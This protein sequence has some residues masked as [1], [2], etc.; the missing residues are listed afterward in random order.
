[1]S[2]TRI[3]IWGSCVSRDSFEHFIPDEFELLQYV[4]RQSAIS[5]YTKPVSLLTPPRLESSFQQRMVAGDY[6]S[7]LRDL[8]AAH[9][10]DVDL[11]LVD[12]TDERLGIYVLPDGTVITRSV[13]L[14][15]SGAEETLPP[16]THFVSFGSG[17]HFEYW[18][19]GIQAVGKMIREAMPR[20]AVAL[21]NIPWAEKTDDGRPSSNSFG[22]TA[23]DANLMFPAYVE[24]AR[25]ALGARLV[26]AEGP[27][28][29]AS[30][31]HP[32]GEAPFHYTESV[33]LDVTRQITGKEGRRVWAEQGT[34]ERTGGHRENSPALTNEEVLR[35]NQLTAVNLGLQIT[36]EGEWRNH[37]IWGRTRASVHQ[38]DFGGT[39]YAFDITID[40][41]GH[42]RIEM[43]PRDR[44]VLPKMIET[45]TRW[46]L[47]APENIKTDRVEI[48]MLPLPDD[49]V[50]KSTVAALAESMSAARRAIES[51]R[52][53]KV[54]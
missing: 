11:M 18:T 29:A 35:A 42:C 21:I 23:A 25:T 15:Q 53:R 31:G 1:M 20:A 52:S 43:F 19:A 8:L 40:D 36:L 27:I 10:R 13:E 28:T 17:E 41:S 50:T 47:C 7:N 26:R 3:F 9:G 2:R 4:A 48:S 44:S 5:A 51:E 6:N 14:I 39:T 33:Y 49:I 32:W 24:A 46:S 45:L 34:G 37:W 30:Q 12:L 54:S 22:V 38:F 16:G